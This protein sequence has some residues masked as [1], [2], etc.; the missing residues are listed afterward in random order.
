M[1]NLNDLIADPERLLAHQAVA[2]ATV[3]SNAIGALISASEGQF[4]SE[5]WQAAHST[6]RFQ[7]DKGPIALA[8]A[9]RGLDAYTLSAD[10]PLLDMYIPATVYPVPTGQGGA[11]WDAIKEQKST[12]LAQVKEQ[13]AALST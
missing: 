2:L 12:M 5:F 7:K 4:S 11:V 9:A 1:P 10:D 13:I 8:L 6:V 3:V